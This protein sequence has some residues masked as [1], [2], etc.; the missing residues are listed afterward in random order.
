MKG[1]DWSRFAGDCSCCWRVPTLK[2]ANLQCPSEATMTYPSTTSRQACIPASWWG[3]LSCSTAYCSTQGAMSPLHNHSEEQ[4]VTLVSGRM[5]VA[6]GDTGVH[7]RTGRRGDLSPPMS[8]INWKH[9]R[10]ASQSRPWAPAGTSGAARRSGRSRQGSE[11]HVRASLVFEFIRAAAAH[12]S[13][14]LGRIPRP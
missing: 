1:M 14:G 12:Q 2:S 13:D 11:R 10:R 9:W 7:T 4:I 8:C 5:R 6:S 3:T